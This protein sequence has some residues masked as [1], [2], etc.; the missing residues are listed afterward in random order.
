MDKN[1]FQ[2]YSEPTIMVLHSRKTPGA[3]LFMKYS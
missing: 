3:R 2:N 1:D